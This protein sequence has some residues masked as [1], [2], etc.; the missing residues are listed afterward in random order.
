MSSDI[1][2]RA[3]AIRGWADLQESA[4]AAG[5]TIDTKFYP[6]NGFDGRWVFVLTDNGVEVLEDEYAGNIRQAILV[7]TRA[8]AQVSA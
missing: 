1:H 6:R 5:L 7:W 3:E 8:R 4:Q 2:F